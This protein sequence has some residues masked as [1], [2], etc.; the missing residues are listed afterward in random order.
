MLYVATTPGNVTNTPLLPT[1]GK[2]I[3]QTGGGDRFIAL[4]IVIGLI[5]AIVAAS[6]IFIVIW[7]KHRRSRQQVKPPLVSNGNGYAAAA[8]Y[9]T[10]SNLEALPLDE[11]HHVGNG[12]TD[13][14]SNERHLV[15]GYA[16]QQPGNGHVTNGLANQDEPP[17]YVAGNEV[18]P[19]NE[20]DAANGANVNQDPQ[21]PVNGQKIT[22]VYM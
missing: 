15:N 5:V 14:N 7:R 21:Q 1:G 12:E 10:K 6:A 16:N 13:S 18:A 4:Y 2:S 20:G 19:A 11:K 9:T 22:P 3:Q 8:G 17:R